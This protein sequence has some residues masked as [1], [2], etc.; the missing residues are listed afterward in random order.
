MMLETLR[1][2]IFDTETTGLSPRDGDRVIEIG[3]VE[4]I[5]RFPTGETFH[6]FINPEGREVHPDA[7]NIHGISNE[8]LNDKPTFAEILPQFEEFF[9]SG[10]LVAHNA[11]FDMGFIN[12]EM[13]RIGKKP[14]DPDRVV[15]TLLIARRKFPGQRNSLDA[16]CSRFDIDNSHREKHGALLDSELLA[17]V[18]LEL[19]GG[20]QASLTLDHSAVEEN[21]KNRSSASASGTVAE[22]R[23]SPLP[24]RLSQEDIDRHKAFVDQ[25][26]DAP[27]WKRAGLV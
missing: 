21:Q 23:P 24:S 8:F 1:E 7:L 13:N 10:N 5:N 15:D 11:S 20:K 14:F 22:A 12:S 2:I 17:E 3:A 4:L 26:G 19:M 16:L 18:Y 25:L 27:V 9:G 6:V